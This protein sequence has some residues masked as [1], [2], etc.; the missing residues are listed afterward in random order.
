MPESNE[1]EVKKFVRCL[2]EEQRK[3][4][5]ADQQSAKCVNQLWMAEHGQKDGQ[6]YPISG[7]KKQQTNCYDLRRE[8]KNAMNMKF[9]LMKPLLE[10]SKG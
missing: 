9:E 7:V 2:F 3:L 6:T 5:L 4:T 1:E 8:L 10:R